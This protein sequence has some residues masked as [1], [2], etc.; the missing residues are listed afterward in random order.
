MEIMVR[1]WTA[2]P[3]F[4]PHFNRSTNRYYG[5]SAEYYGDLK[6]KGLEPYSGEQTVPNLRKPYIPSQTANELYQ[7]IRETRHGRKLD[8]KINLG[9]NFKDALMELSR[10]KPVAQNQ[11]DRD[12]LPSHYQ[13][14]GFG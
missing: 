8:A 11:I 10:H 7:T 13:K 2:K 5:T 1:K 14:G 4:R 12:K 3:V 6:S 9:D